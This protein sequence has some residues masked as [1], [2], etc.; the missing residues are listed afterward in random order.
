MMVETE[1]KDALRPNSRSRGAA[2][3]WPHGS[4]QASWDPQLVQPP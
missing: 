1:M 4:Q 3:R 2:R